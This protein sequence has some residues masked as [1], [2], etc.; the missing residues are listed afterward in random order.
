MP[1]SFAAGDANGPTYGV[2]SY[3]DACHVLGFDC[4]GLSL[5]AW[6]GLG[7]YM[8]HYAASQYSEAGSVHPSVDQLQPGDLT[9][10]STGGVSGIHHVAIYVG[11]GEVI[12]APHTG[13]VVSFSPIW[14]NGYYG[15]TR[16]LHLSRPAPRSSRPAHRPA[17]VRGLLSCCLASG[18]A[19]SRPLTYRDR[20][21]TRPESL[22]V[23]AD[24]RSVYRPC[25]PT[26]DTT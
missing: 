13:T 11:N 23:R 6:A 25:T 10:W 5:Y 3:S 16:P 22:H 20:R 26:G 8:D 7:L 2:C 1:Y 18:P 21:R 24:F 19:G 15:A 14:M 9:F 12:Q 17:P 4:S